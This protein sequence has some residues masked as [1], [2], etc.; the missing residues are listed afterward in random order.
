MQSADHEKWRNYL[1]GE[2]VWKNIIIC[3]ITDGTVE[4][5][6]LSL[7]EEMGL[8][9]NDSKQYSLSGK[10]MQAHLYEVYR[11]TLTDL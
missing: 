7:L 6:S 8:F 3:I 2:D 4:A 1:S 11:S 5:S 9:W 10:D